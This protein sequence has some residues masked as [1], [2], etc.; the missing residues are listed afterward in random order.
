MINVC[1]SIMGSGK[2]SATITYINEHPEE[3]IIYVT[4]YLEEAARIKFGCPN[5]NFIE[6]SDKIKEF[7][8]RKSEHTMDLIK[9]GMNVATTHQSFSMYTEETLDSIREQNYTLIIDENLEILERFEFS[10]ADIDI[11][12]DSG[13]VKNEDGIYTLEKHDYPGGMF[14]DLFKIMKHR[15]MM[16]VKTDNSS[17]FCWILPPDLITSFNKVFILTYL[18]EGQGLHHFCNMCDIPYKKIGIHKYDDG[19]Y[20]FVDEPD[21]IPDY[22]ES[23]KDKIE[24]VDGKI[25]DVGKDRTALSMAWF[26]KNGDGV[27]QTRDNL[28]NFFNNMCRGEGSDKRLWGTYKIGFDK[29][30]GKGYTKAFTPFNMR[31]TNAYSQCNCLAYPANIYMNVGEALFY[32]KH[33]VEIDQDKYTL[34]TLVQWIWRS[35]IRNGESVKLYLPS[36]RMRDI[37]NNWMEGLTDDRKM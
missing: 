33:G 28:Y 27:E 7:H 19:T 4:P 6:P 15:D 25:N 26:Q 1:D 8:F 22:I 13:Y 20:R 30:K 2:T 12:T 11:L 10:H 18:F 37:L 9:R 16:E 29:L 3:K 14:T 5:A 24:I 32:K 21:Y 31:A 23:I 17:L 35:A 34:S 36:R